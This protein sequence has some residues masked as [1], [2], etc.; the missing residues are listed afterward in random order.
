V[1]TKPTTVTVWYLEMLDPS[2]LQPAPLP[3]ER[4]AVVRA[5][6][7][8]PE[9]NRFLYTT[10][11]A[12]WY[13]LD[14]LDW[15]D[16]QW[17]AYLDRPEVETWVAYLAGTPAGYFELTQPGQPGEG[18]IQI[19][20][21]GLLPRFIGRGIGGYLLTYA[22]RRAWALGT[23]R[24]TVNTCSL[25]GPHALANYQARG[26]RVYEERQKLEWLPDTPTR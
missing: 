9:L 11:G 10:V 15:S 7:S 20:Y 16:A 26:F 12:D 6:I 21:F 24:V 14:R 5:E 4:L 3:D 25:D 18:W 22:V 23:Q 2:W 13:W 19:E 1:A 8:S 17:L